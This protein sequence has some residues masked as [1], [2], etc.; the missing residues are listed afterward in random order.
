MNSLERM[1]EVIT[2]RTLTPMTPSDV[3]S[4]DVG[5]VWT[6]NAFDRRDMCNKQSKALEAAKRAGVRV[7]TR[8]T[9]VLSNWS[10]TVER[11]A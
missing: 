8:R 2:R 6:I 11:V 3:Y 4:M 9:K 10:V 5:D 7:V 1:A